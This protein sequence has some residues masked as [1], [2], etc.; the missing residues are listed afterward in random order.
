MGFQQCPNCEQAV[1]DRATHCPRCGHPL[2]PYGQPYAPYA[3]PVYAPP[4]AAGGSNV[5]SILAIV[6]GGIAFLFLPVVFGPIG[7]I[8]GIIATVR[9]ERLG[10]VG[11]VVSVL[12]LVVGMLLGYLAWRMFWP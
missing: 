9:K 10:V 1:S 6:M 4:Q 5:L 8:L 3:P 11:L 7:I 12:G 2:T